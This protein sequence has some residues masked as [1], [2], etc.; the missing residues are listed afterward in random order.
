MGD[1]WSFRDERADEIDIVGFSVQADDGKAGKVDE[2]SH[3]A[4]SCCIVV[5]TGGLR[6]HKVLLPAGLVEEIDPS[7]ES[8]LVRL[9]KSDVK[10]APEYD[11]FGPQDD[12]YRARVASHFAS[13]WA[14]SEART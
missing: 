6:G 4:G 14:S 9:S 12:D 5:D 7:S 3:A 11:P 10:D 8:V 1:I 13:A 2:A